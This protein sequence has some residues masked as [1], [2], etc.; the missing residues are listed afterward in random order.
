MALYLKS[1]KAAPLHFTQSLGFRAL[2]AHVSNETLYKLLPSLQ[3]HVSE[4]QKKFC[5][6]KCSPCLCISTLYINGVPPFS[7]S[8]TFHNFLYLSS[9]CIYL[10]LSCSFSEVHSVA[11]PRYFLKVLRYHL[12][13][14]WVYNIRY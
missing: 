7:S 4:C 2:R 1:S 10:L 12:Q 13:N 9:C 11:L 8:G 3:T 5:L 14:G 6:K